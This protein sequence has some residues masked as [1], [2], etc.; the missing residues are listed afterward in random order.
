M[1][2]RAT[3]GLFWLV[4]FFI[5]L[6]LIL[7]LF[8]T[9]FFRFLRLL[10][11]ACFTFLSSCFRIIGFY[12]SGLPVLPAISISPSSVAQGLSLNYSPVPTSPMPTYQPD[13]ATSPSLAHQLAHPKPVL[14]AFK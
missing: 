7:G 10:V 13:S 14:L 6:R 2:V 4:G 12:S 1:R 3:P 5:R 8:F 9:A 11:L